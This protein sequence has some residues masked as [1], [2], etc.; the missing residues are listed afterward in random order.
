MVH[1]RKLFSLFLMVI[2]IIAASLVWFDYQLIFKHIVKTSDRIIKLRKDAVF[3]QA[4]TEYLPFVKNEE[5]RMIKE[6]AN[7]T[8]LD[9]FTNALEFLYFLEERA[10]RSENQIKVNVQEGKTSAF[11]VELT[12]SFA[13]LVRFLIEVGATPTQVELKQIV[14]S[15]DDNSRLKTDLV[16]RPLISPLP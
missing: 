9:P 12:G 3:F 16:F 1:S 6:R 5:K 2:L 15:G 11:T 7:L 8:A 4:R 13:H 10:R 14:K